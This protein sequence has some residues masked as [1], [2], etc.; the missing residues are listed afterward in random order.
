[1][2]TASDKRVAIVTGAASGIGRATVERLVA[3]GVNVVAVDLDRDR[4]G[5]LVAQGIDDSVEVVVGDVTDSA[6]NAAAVATALERFGR[7]DA[8]VFNAGVSMSGDL[9]DL[10]MEQFD[11]ALDIN[12]RAVALGMRS[13]V[14]TMRAAGVGRIVVT[15]STSGIG[16]DPNMWAYNTSKGA[17]I[18]LVRAAAVDLGPDNITVNAVCPGPTET[19]M[20]ARIKG[21]PQVHDRLRRAVPLQR[22]GQPAEIA[23]VI[24]FLVSSEASF[25]NGA[26]I[27]VD[28][29]IT[30]STGQFL[31]RGNMP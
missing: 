4:F 13:V 23:A 7:L 26:V 16:G 27:P 29:G 14:P 2:T 28:G 1:M 18:N 9:L 8:A 15:A 20:T 17:V 10:P 12:V 21:A 5:W 19:E 31:P 22:W 11:R 25:V 24:A 30:A 6:L 3:A